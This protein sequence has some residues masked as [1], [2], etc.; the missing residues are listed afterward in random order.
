MLVRASRDGLLRSAHDLSDGGLAQALVESC[1][2]HDHGVEVTLPAGS[3]PFVALFSESAGRV[4]V[5]LDPAAEAEFLALCAEAGVPVTALGAV[6]GDDEP[7]LTVVGQLSL[8]LAQ[9]REGWAATLP[10][11]LAS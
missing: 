4:L 9:V 2:R 1:L 5:S 11:V 3:D 7:S 6:T 10:A 8:P